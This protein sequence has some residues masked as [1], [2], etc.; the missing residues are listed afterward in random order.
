[1][2]EFVYA[3]LTSQTIDVFLQDSSSSTGQGLAGLAFNT[4]NLV[5]S[6][7]KGATGSRVA[8]TLATQTVGGAYSSGGFAEIDAT[9]MTGV[10]R[11]DLPN[12]A[13]D[14]EGFVTLYLYGATNLLPTAL[15]IDCRAVPA[16]VKKIGADT[17][18][19]T[20][21]KDFADAGYDP[22]TNKVQGVLLVDTTTTLTT[23]PSI[24]T[25]WL[26]AD[27]LA[28]DA[29]S[30][31]QS[32]L[33][34]PTNITQAT[35][36]TVATNNDKTGYSLTQGFPVNFSDLG[37]NASGHVERVVLVDTTTTNTD[38]RGTDSALLASNYT[39]PPTTGSIADAVLTESI[40]DHRN[41]A[42]S[43]AKY[44]YQIRQA[45]LTIDGTVSNAITPTTLTF[46]SNVAATT[47]AYA[48][49]VLLFTTGP[50]A[51]EN[52]PIIS[53]NSTNGVFL[54]E[55]ALTAAPSDGDEFVVIAGSH[56]HSVAD[57]QAGLATSAAVA[58]EAVKT[59]NIL[60]GVAWILADATGAIAAP[61]SATATAILTT[62]GATYTVQY[63][64]LTST[65]ARTAPTLS[66]V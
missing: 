17:Q 36:I 59:A 41:V 37:I 60:D 51:G 40:L 23:L 3:G 8:I 46:A 57:I 2:S 21:L 14:T 34:T 42:H 1:M 32:G 66:K 62:F 16:D 43:L 47:S 31:I 38:M 20:D 30:E 39:A 6:Y 24:P 7:R 12:G 9:H 63:A 58:A 4:A 53:Y 11:L 13:V 44:I 5:A 49:A 64:G 27:G 26:T 55:E 65:G 54:L 45:N 35:G 48:H 18:S 10:Y 33:A 61:Q 56:V 22:S 52:S 25:N 29:V 50:L 15:R 19:A 28:T